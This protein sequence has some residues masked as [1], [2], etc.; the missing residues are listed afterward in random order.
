MSFDCSAAAYVL[1]YL[2]TADESRSRGTLD[3]IP[4]LL[5]FIELVYTNVVLV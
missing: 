3:P 5:F 2:S 1:I 4:L